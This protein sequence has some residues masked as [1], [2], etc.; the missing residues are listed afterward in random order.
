[1]L[2][3][4]AAE[5]RLGFCGW[6]PLGCGPLGLGGSVFAFVF[7][8]VQAYLLFA[9]SICIIAAL[10]LAFPRGKPLTAHQRWNAILFGAAFIPAVSLSGLAAGY[11]RA[12]LGSAPLFNPVGGALIAFVAADFLY[13]WYHRAQHAVPWLWRF[14][15]VHHSMEELGA[16]ASYHHLLEAPFKAFLVTLPVA[17]FLPTH[18]GLIGFVLALQG[19]YIHSTT[20]INFGRFAWIVADN[21][22]HRIHHSTEARHLNRNFGALTLLWD[23]LFGTAHFPEKDEWPEIGL[24]GQPEPRTI[25]DYVLAP[26]YPDLAASDIAATTVRDPDRVNV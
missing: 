5:A 25:V 20:S 23:A 1:M 17:F 13:Y 8:A 3:G 11:V 6:F 12:R 16:G 14:H 26:K 2:I 7:G 4:T 19:P 18:L 15:A 22:V 21:R 24:K 10:E 9:A